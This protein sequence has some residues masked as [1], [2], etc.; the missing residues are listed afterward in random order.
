[1]KSTEFF[2]LKITACIIEKMIKTVPIRIYIAF[3]C[4]FLEI[5]YNLLCVLLYQFKDTIYTT[6]LFSHQ[7]RKF[8][9]N[10]S[11]FLHEK[12]HP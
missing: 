10:L 4:A 1:M 11:I 12:L 6:I 2:M 8:Y 9:C 7:L 5:Q 3:Q